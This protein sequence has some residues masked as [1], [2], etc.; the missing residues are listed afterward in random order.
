MVAAKATLFYFNK[1]EKNIALILKKKKF[2]FLLK[3]TFKSTVSF[4]VQLID[5]YRSGQPKKASPFF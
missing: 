4:P 1:N 5:I 3:T 2:F